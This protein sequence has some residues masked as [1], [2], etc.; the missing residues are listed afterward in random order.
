[1]TWAVFFSV[2]G[3]FDDI[4]IKKVC[5]TQESDAYNGVVEG[6]AEEFGVDP[7]AV[8]IRLVIRVFDT[9]EAN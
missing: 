5:A 6:V 4:R 8:V 1:M 3:V 9:V 2:K 7:S